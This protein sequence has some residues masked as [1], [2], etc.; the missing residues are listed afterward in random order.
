MIILRFVSSINTLPFFYLKKKMDAEMLPKT[1]AFTFSPKPTA[2]E[3]HRV[4]VLHKYEGSE[5][6][7]I[8][9]ESERNES[10][11]GF[12]ATVEDSTAKEFV[13]PS[14]EQASR[15][16]DYYSAI[17]NMREG[18]RIVVYVWPA[19]ENQRI[20]ITRTPNRRQRNDM[21][22]HPYR[23]RMSSKR[24]LERESYTRDESSSEN[25]SNGG[26]LKIFWRYQKKMYAEK[27]PAAVSETVTAKLAVAVGGSAIVAAVLIPFT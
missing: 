17:A 11:P 12:F 3:P 25:S 19:K 16:T 18:K 23:R 15:T 5:Q 22:S 14:Y 21:R 4:I 26:F 7:L 2:T 9:C 24:R 10:A 13:Y 1:Q 6:Y 27:M 20:L 8:K